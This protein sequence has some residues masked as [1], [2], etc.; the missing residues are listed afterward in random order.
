MKEQFAKLIDVKTLVT[1]ALV[2]TVVYL[3][4][5]SKLEPDKLYTMSM[6]VIAFYFGRKIGE[7]TK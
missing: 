1:F 7:L 6:V 2:G 5:T 4:V 3:A